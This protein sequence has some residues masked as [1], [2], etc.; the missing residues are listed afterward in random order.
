MATQKGVRISK[1]LLAI[2]KKW[3]ET[4]LNNIIHFLMPSLNDVKKIWRF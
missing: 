4:E 1:T 2:S 3:K